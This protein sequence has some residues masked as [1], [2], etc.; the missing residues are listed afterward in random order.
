M[1]PN[2]SGNTP[3]TT[4]FECYLQYTQPGMMHHGA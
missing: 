1:K 2:L 3:V 4:H